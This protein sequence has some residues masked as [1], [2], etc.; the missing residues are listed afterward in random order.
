MVRCRHL[1]VGLSLILFLVT[2]LWGQVIKADS[3]EGLSDGTNE[4]V[5]MVESPEGITIPPEIL[6]ELLEEG[7][8]YSD[9][10]QGYFLSLLFKSSPRAVL[11]FKPKGITWHEYTVKL[12]EYVESRRLME[13]VD[14]AKKERAKKADA[15]DYASKQEILTRRHRVSLQA[16]EKMKKLRLSEEEILALRTLGDLYHVSE[17]E[18]LREFASETDLKALKEK[19]TE[20]IGY[21]DAAVGLVVSEEKAGKGWAG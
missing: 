19:I 14:R 1:G 18:L 5:G 12:Q 8:S 7:Y 10:V 6:A 11:K 16:I 3:P 2:G 15:V 4:E 9:I 21:L 17:E 20:V 13:A